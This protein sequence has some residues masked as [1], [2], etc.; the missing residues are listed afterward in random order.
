ML[1]LLLLLARTS[2]SRIWDEPEVFR[3][4]AMPVIREYIFSRYEQF[5]DSALTFRMLKSHVSK[6]L[7][8]PADVL[9]FRDDLS[10]VIETVTDEIANG[11]EMGSVPL[12]DCKRLIYHPPLD[13]SGRDEL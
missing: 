10:E 3:E 12:D 4:H 5:A 9:K 11:C 7:N 6:K 2:A 1:L 13:S 8:I